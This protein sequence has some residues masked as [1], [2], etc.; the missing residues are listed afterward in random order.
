[1]AQEKA[2]RTADNV[3]EPSRGAPKPKQAAAAVR[4][5]RPER[6]A[7]KSRTIAVAKDTIEQAEALVKRGLPRRDCSSSSDD[8]EHNIKTNEDEDEEEDEHDDQREYASPVNDRTSET[9]DGDHAEQLVPGMSSAPSHRQLAAS[10]RLAWLA[11]GGGGEGGG[12]GG[13]GGGGH[14]G[15]TETN[16]GPPQ[17]MLKSGYA[18][19]AWKKK[20]TKQTQAKQSSPSG[21]GGPAPTSPTSPQGSHSQDKIALSPESDQLLAELNSTNSF[22]LSPRRSPQ[23]S[24]AQA[25]AKATEPAAPAV[26]PSRAVAGLQYARASYWVCLY[27]FPGGPGEQA[28][29]LHTS[30]SWG[31]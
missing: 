28:H 27:S 24:T 12:G 14:A 3:R 30:R 17:G 13:G 5:D 7:P 31:G 4:E 20:Q 9:A 16:N 10:T 29:L 25:K 15:T 18:E 19:M 2:L 22:P 21:R 11:G 6:S 26:V 1:M 23:L 8:D